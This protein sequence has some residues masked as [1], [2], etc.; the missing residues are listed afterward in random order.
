[1]DNLCQLYDYGLAAAVFFASLQDVGRYRRIII[2]A[3]LK[4]PRFVITIR[5]AQRADTYL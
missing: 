3:M 4:G 2:Q 1:M 5:T